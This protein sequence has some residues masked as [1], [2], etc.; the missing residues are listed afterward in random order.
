VEAQNVVKFVRSEEAKLKEDEGLK[1]L[2]NK[3]AGDVLVAQSHHGV[4]MLSSH[5]SRVL[6]EVKDFY[7]L[8]DTYKVRL[9]EEA[10]IL[11][12]YLEE[13]KKAKEK[14]D[15][16]AKEKA[17]K[18]AKDEKKEDKKEEKKDD[19]KEKADKEEKRK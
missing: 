4:T 18:A 10:K 5:I 8:M 15:K 13:E 3:E 14:E 9:V 7:D 6:D 2:S 1:S 17:E 11:A 16:E 12:D 19:A